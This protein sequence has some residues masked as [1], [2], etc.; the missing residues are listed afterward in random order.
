MKIRKNKFDYLMEA[1]CLI[2]LV[3]LTLYL[4]VTWRS[5]PDKIPAHYD[6]AGNIDRWGKKTEILIVP[7]MSWF[8]YLVITALE[9]IPAIWN[10]G[11]KVT[12][13]NGWRVYRTLKYIIKSTKLIMVAVFFYLTLN[14]ISGKPLSGWFTLISL[15]IIFGDLIFWS[16]RLFKVR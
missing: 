6:W 11:V 4:I 15:G 14:S 1:V 16:W 9:Q 12:A 5:I 7:I 8:L 13:E 2:L 3:G 10:T